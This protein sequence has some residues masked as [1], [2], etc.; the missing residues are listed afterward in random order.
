MRLFYSSTA[1]SLVFLSALCE[2]S[3]LHLARSLA[4]LACSADFTEEKRDMIAKA[5]AAVTSLS[6]PGA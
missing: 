5:L 2:Q 6:G 4:V 3:A 1:H